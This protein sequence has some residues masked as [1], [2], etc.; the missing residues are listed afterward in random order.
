MQRTNASSFE[1]KAFSPSNTK[2][3]LISRQDLIKIENEFS[4]ILEKI[5]IALYYRV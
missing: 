2:K 3:R 5:C 1:V 4:W